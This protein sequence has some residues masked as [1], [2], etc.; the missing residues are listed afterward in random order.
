MQELTKMIAQALVDAPEQVNVT[1]SATGH[2]MMLNLRVVQGD[3]GKI[4]GKQG[5]AVNAFRAILNAVA[6]KE[7]NGLS[8][9]SPMTKVKRAGRRIYLHTIQQNLTDSICCEGS[10]MYP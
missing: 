10:G 3:A 2:R 8:S 5:R 9:K 1:S 7:K 4:I 6:A